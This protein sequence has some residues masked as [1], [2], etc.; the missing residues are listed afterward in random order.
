[1]YLKHETRRSAGP[2]P[3]REPL[4]LPEENIQCI[5]RWCTGHLDVIRDNSSSEEVPEERR[6]RGGEINIRSNCGELSWAVWKV[7]FSAKWAESAEIKNGCWDIF[8][9]ICLTNVRQS[10]LNPRRITPTTL[11]F[12]KPPAHETIFLSSP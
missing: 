8:W 1:M 2:K 12:L 6:L 5:Q 11:A 7:P 3:V 9:D 10:V 4:Q